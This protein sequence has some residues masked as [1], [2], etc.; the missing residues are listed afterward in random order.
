MD[1]ARKLYR[2]RK[3]K[4]LAGV[5]GG[6]GEYTGIDPTIVRI[7]WILFCLL[8]LVGVI[9]YIIAAIVIPEEPGA[10]STEQGEFRTY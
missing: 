1:S 2:S 10:P 7:L 5:C 8:Y 3:N 9:A 6:I 4:W